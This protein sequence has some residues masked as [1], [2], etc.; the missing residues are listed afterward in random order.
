MFG[1]PSA[2]SFRLWSHFPPENSRVDA[3]ARVCS[4]KSRGPQTVL[5]HRMPETAFWVS[6]SYPKSATDEAFADAGM[7]PRSQAIRCNLGDLESSHSMEGSFEE[8]RHDRVQ[9]LPHH[10]PASSARPCQRPFGQRVISAC[11][12]AGSRCAIPGSFHRRTSK[13]QRI[14]GCAYQKGFAQRGLK[15]H[16]KTGHTG[17][18][19]KRPTEGSRNL[20]VVLCRS[21][22]GQV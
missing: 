22:F 11:P 18:L 21:L 10:R 14:R 12:F 9:R 16:C 1:W 17:S 20:D 13:A 19:Q 8:I 4:G 15:G 7:K 5:M 2:E 3:C 6:I